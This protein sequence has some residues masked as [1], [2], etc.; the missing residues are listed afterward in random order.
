[1]TTTE[2][3]WEIVASIAKENQRFQDNLEQNRIEADKQAKERAAEF[4]KRAI[5]AD[6][7]AIEADKQ[8]KERAAEFDKQA[9]ERAAEFDKQAKERAA[10]A[11]K[12]AIEADKRAIEA[13]KRAIEAEKRAIEADKQAKERAAEFDKQAKE[14]A[15]E[16]EK[17]AAEADAQA[18]ERAAEAD[19]RFAET[20]RVIKEGQAAVDRQIEKVDQQ[21]EKNAL[22]LE[23][24]DKKMSKFSGF[25]SNYSYATEEYFRNAILLR[26]LTIGKVKF[27]YIKPNEG[28]IL[29]GPDGGEIELDGLLINGE[30]VG[31]LEVKKHLHIQDIAKIEKSTLP[32]FKKLY[33]EYRDH[34]L[35][36]I[37]AWESA[38]KEAVEVAREH[39]CVT[40]T[41]KGD[42]AVVDTTHIRLRNAEP[43]S[44]PTP[45]GPI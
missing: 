4:D 5:E 22:G 6:K 10:E 25:V 12:R 41:R 35:M 43:V 20:E 9:K 34:T 37:L 23:E 27:N 7:R 33:P 19:K 45:P 1:M 3:L 31:I 30:C 32:K 13:D 28:K 17:R 36:I 24:L 18:K 8:A 21:L 16:A 29:P 11:E 44:D 40:M 42:E 38:D 15:A 26:K 39:G 14:R 2:E